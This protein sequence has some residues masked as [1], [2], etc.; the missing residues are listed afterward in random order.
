[1]Y[2]QTG[3]LQEEMSIATKLDDIVTIGKESLKEIIKTLE[4]PYVNKKASIQR[5]ATRALLKMEKLK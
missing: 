2:G 5:I 3:Q 1:M 4:G